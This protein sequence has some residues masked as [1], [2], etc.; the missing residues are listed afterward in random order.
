V[1]RWIFYQS[2][3]KKKK[4]DELTKESKNGKKSQKVREKD[5]GNKNML[6]E[7]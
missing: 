1:K 4:G 5:G 3:L 6:P 2:N 7:F